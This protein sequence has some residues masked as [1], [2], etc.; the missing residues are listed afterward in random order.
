MVMSLS[1]LLQFAGI[2]SGVKVLKLNLNILGIVL[3][4]F[5]PI[6]VT[7]FIPGLT[8][9]FIAVLAYFGI[10]KTLDS[11]ASLFQ[12]MGILIISAVLQAFVINTVLIPMLS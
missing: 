6:L 4:T 3:L 8:G 11:S 9:F 10:I 2:F 5:I 1:L 12:M 7:S